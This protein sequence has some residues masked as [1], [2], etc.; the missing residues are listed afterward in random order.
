MNAEFLTETELHIGQQLA[1]LWRNARLLFGDVAA[2]DRACSSHAG[3]RALEVP[4]ARAQ[5][6]LLARVADDLS[7]LLV[8]A[9][10]GYEM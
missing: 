7:G 1:P 4:A 10:V 2:L 8:L 3:D 5:H 6:I 9:A